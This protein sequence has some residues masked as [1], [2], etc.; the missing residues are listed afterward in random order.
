[1]K[2][3]SGLFIKYGIPERYVDADY[4]KAISRVPD[5]SVIDDFVFGDLLGL[6]IWGVNGCGKTYLSSALM[7][8]MMESGVHSYR[9]DAFRLMAQY[10]ENKNW[11]IPEKYIQPKLLVLD[12]VGKETETKIGV[13]VMERLLRWRTDYSK[14]TVIISN[15]GLSHLVERYGATFESTIRGYYKSVKLPDEDMRLK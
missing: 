4:K 7:K 3:D 15:M 9:S 13:T 8:T 6:F 11:V 2:F 14:K 10:T 12:E 1:M 5:E